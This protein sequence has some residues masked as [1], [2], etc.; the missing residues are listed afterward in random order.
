MNVDDLID[1]LVDERSLEALEQL[2]LSASD[3]VLE[4]LIHA[5]GRVSVDDDLET[6]DDRIVEAIHQHVVERR[7]VGILMDALASGDAPTREFALG[8]LSEIGDVKAV[9]AMINLLA[10]KD[11]DVRDAAAEHL[12]LLTHYDFGKDPA[13]WRAWHERLLKGQ[14]EQAKEEIE[15]KQRLLRMQMKGYRGK[16]GESDDDNPDDD[17]RGGRRFG[18]DDDSGERSRFDDDDDDRRGRPSRD[19]DDDD[20]GRGKPSRDDDDDDRGRGRASAD[21]DDDRNVLRDDHR[22]RGGW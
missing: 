9:P 16:R 19:D 14:E 10:D 1:A 7:P 22:G 6:E 18:D 5:A 12:A 2:T 11:G 20:R 17:D 13:K 8:C 21:D 3:E 15:D 4:A